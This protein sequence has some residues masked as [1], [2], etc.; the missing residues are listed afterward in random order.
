[1]ADMDWTDTQDAAIK[2][3]YRKIPARL[4]GKQLG[5]TRNAII[6]RAYRLG[7]QLPQSP[8]ALAREV[9]MP[10]RPGDAIPAHLVAEWAA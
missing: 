9:K 6:G 5:V 2:A 1:M 10:W 4:L 3:N 8:A 7:R